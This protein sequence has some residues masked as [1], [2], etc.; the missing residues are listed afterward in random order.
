MYALICD[1]VQRKS[2]A[3]DSSNPAW[4]VVHRSRGDDLPSRLLFDDLTGQVAKVSISHDG[5]YATA[6]C[7]AANEPIP[8]DVG[9]EAAAR[10]P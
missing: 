9:G 10:M 6:V 4:S 1:E 5:D 3:E 8:G 2:Q 7:L